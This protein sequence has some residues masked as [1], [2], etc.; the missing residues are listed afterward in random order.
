MPS[1]GMR[2]LEDIEGAAVGGGRNGNAANDGQ[3][4]QQQQ[5][6]ALLANLFG[7]A[8]ANAGGAAPPPMPTMPGGGMS[9]DEIERRMNG[10]GGGGGGGSAAPPRR[11]D[12]AILKEAAAK[13]NHRSGTPLPGS[14]E[15]YKD[16]LPWYSK[17]YPSD[18]ENRGGA[19]TGSGSGAG[20][21]VM[22]NATPTWTFSTSR[23]AEIID[24]WSAPL[25][26]P[27]QPQREEEEEE[28]SVAPPPP[29]DESESARRAPPATGS[30]APGAHAVVGALQNLAKSNSYLQDRVGKL[31]DVIESK[32]P[33]FDDPAIIQKARDLGAVI[34]QSEDAAANANAA[35]E[36]PSATPSDWQAPLRA[37]MP[38]GNDPNASTPARPMMN[39]QP[40]APT[41]PT[42]TPPQQQQQQQQR[43]ASPSPPPPPPP[44]L[45]DTA[46]YEPSVE[47]CVM[48][49]PGAICCTRSEISTDD[50][51]RSATI[52]VHT[53]VRRAQGDAGIH[54][55]QMTMSD[56]VALGA[57]AIADKAGELRDAKM[58]DV[59]DK[60][61]K[62][63]HDRIQQ[64]L[65][66]GK[67]IWVEA[68]H[69]V[70][71][72]YGHPCYKLK[73]ECTKGSGA[74]I[75]CVFKPAIEGNGE[76]WHRAGM[77]YV[78]Y[79][80]SRMLGMDSV[81]PCAYRR[82][83]AGIELDYKHFDE[84]AFMYWSDDA[85]DLEKTAGFQQ[86]LD[87]GAW[88]EGIDPRVVLSDTRIL[89]VLLQNS[90]RHAGHFLF[91][92]HW[93]D[94]GPRPGSEKPQNVSAVMNSNVSDGEKNDII[95]R[96]VS[97][98][99]KMK[100]PVLIDHAAAFRPEAFVSMEHENAF[101]TG[102][103]RCVDS[104]TYLR[105]RFLDAKAIADELGFVLDAGE[106]AQLLERRDTILAYLDVLVQ[107]NGF[108]ATV[109][110]R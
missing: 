40:P 63:M 52:T 55:D 42:P 84:G 106:Q 20:G 26:V 5:Q 2:S 30:N 99:G 8:T 68:M 34:P 31:L 72:K 96:A 65:Q 16:T 7:S 13:A 48:Q 45:S 28:E 75:D 88:G 53:T 108:E 43:A 94:G 10:G 76:G 81:P 90:D 74:V 59:V 61:A 64:I 27:P 9:M 71:G 6:P 98:G 66:N 70:Q 1:G 105:L 32:G 73:L 110:N 82:P 77:E 38:K 92:R 21:S 58:Q 103:T 97:L 15:W 86:A 12:E 91:G 14:G 80:L 3:H 87:T 44:P 47:V 102:P 46:T 107:K 83:S 95:K 51:K 23:E 17:M 101:Q 78:A 35:A 57:Q 89:D 62:I 33:G 79:K 104:K 67:I 29:P 11:D 41:T 24:S 36:A 39:Y 19:G 93:T 54:S 22:N 109:I 100:R 25:D 18:V 50:A 60:E 56:F 69:E 49:H 37:E 4:H 85:D